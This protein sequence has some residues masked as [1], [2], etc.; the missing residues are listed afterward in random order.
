MLIKEL[1]LWIS[2]FLQLSR[3]DSSKCWR[4]APSTST[5]TST[6]VSAA[7]EMDFCRFYHVLN[8]DNILDVLYNPEIVLLLML[9]DYNTADMINKEG[10]L[11][12]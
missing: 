3:L 9:R 6:V 2:S 1:V 4:R 5:S 8:S 10:N 12:I 11:L 7:L